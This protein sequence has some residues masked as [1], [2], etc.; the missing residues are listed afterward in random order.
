MNYEK[1]CIY[2]V[3]IDGVEDAT[4]KVYTPCTTC[5]CMCI[6]GAIQGTY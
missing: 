3:A 6:L 5:A 1:T 2:I 4:I